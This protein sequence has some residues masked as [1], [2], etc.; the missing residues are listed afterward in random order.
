MKLRLRYPPTSEYMPQ[1]AENAVWAVKNINDADL[2]YDVKSLKEVDSILQKFHQE[3]EWE[4]KFAETVFCL[5]AYT[6]EVIVRHAR[7][8]WRDAARPLFDSDWP[9]IEM[10]NGHFVNPVGKAIKRVESGP[11]ES[12]VKFY[13]TMVAPFVKGK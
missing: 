13:E 8:K 3:G 4:E 9:V 2:H 6:G 11:T 10:P 5:G 7:G 1:H 12:V